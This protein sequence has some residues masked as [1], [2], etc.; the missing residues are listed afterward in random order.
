[1]D[2]KRVCVGREIHRKRV[3]VGCGG[4]MKDERAAGDYQKSWI[5]IKYYYAYYSK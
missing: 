4:G 1:M 2:S 3:C 5:R